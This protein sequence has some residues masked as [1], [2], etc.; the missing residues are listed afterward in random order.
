MEITTDIINK[1]VLDIDTESVGIGFYEGEEDLSPYIPI[2]YW[3]LEEVLEDAE[4]ALTM[5]RAVQL[6]YSDKELLL[7][8]LGHVII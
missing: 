7:T 8:K 3:H 1:L 6:Y 2:C 4:V 5:C